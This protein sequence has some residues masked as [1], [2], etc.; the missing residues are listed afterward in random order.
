MEPP[1]Q[2]QHTPLPSSAGPEA[3]PQ[4]A[5]VKHAVAVEGPRHREGASVKGSF[6][7]YSWLDSCPSAGDLSSCSQRDSAWRTGW[8]C[9]EALVVLA[10]LK[11]VEELNTGDAT[12]PVELFTYSGTSKHKQPCSLFVLVKMQLG[13]VVSDSSVSCSRN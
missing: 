2:C 4:C 6:W 1:C 8:A 5:G 11:D 9:V 3:W 7:L 13:V 10:G 12:V